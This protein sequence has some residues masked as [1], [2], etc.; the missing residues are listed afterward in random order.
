MFGCVGHI[1]CK[2]LINLLWQ[3][4]VL[5]ESCQAIYT[6]TYILPASIQ[7]V[8]AALFAKY[9]IVKTICLLPVLVAVTQLCWSTKNIKESAVCKFLF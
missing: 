2:R 5:S 1:K 6:Q 9:C 3:I 8:N 7:V 4:M